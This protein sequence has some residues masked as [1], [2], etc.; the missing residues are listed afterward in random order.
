ME[1]GGDSTLT[2]LRVSD[3]HCESE[4]RFNRKV[5]IDALLSDV[6]AL[7]AEGLRPDF[8]AFTGDVAY[9]GAA[10]EYRI[11]ANEFFEPLLSSLAIQRDHLF[12]VPGNH[13]VNR[14]KTA[15]LKN[16][17]ITIKSE[18]D[19]RKMLHDEHNKEVLL[20]PLAEYRAFVRSFLP[21]LRF[22]DES[23]CSFQQVITKGGFGIRIVGL[24]ST[25]LSGF[26]VN[27][28]GIVEDQG[29]L[30]IGEWQ[31]FMEDFG[32]ADL[33]IVLVH[34]SVRMAGRC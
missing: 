28:T 17:S 22:A 6:R 31:T 21:S 12:I 5:V 2:W 29:K 33:T 10:S 27:E 14:R 1:A 3:L 32:H 11:A 8:V 19:I 13:D 18:D 25:W 23:L 20:S 24:N 15:L 30:A 9:H 16:V 7:A 26:N 34:H 4:D